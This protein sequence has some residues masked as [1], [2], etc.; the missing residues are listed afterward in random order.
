MRQL[1]DHRC[2]RQAW[3]FE[4]AKQRTTVTKALEIA[5]RRLQT[6]RMP[7]V[8]AAALALARLR[9]ELTEQAESER[10]ARVNACVA[11]LPR[12]G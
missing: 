3:A 11:K 7:T 12:T 4:R 1:F 9:D 5:V 2:A 10:A 6:S 8:L